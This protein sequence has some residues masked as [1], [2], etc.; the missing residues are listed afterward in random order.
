MSDETIY[1]IAWGNY[2]KKKKKL[3]LYCT[4]E[5]QIAFVWLVRENTNV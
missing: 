1:F 3:P 5:L 2:L 4:F